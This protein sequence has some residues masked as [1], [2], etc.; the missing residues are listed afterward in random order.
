M[1]CGK[2]VV[3]P[4]EAQLWRQAW[5]EEG[6]RKTMVEMSVEVG[7]KVR[8][9]G[10]RGETAGPREIWMGGSMWLSEKLEELT[11]PLK[12]RGYVV[13]TGGVLQRSL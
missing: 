8:T 12:L 5:S 6:E 3:K 4:V 10:P 13:S 7:S 9:P 11:F 1:T 2:I